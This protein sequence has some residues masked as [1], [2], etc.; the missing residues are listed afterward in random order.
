[1]KNV[2]IILI[3][4]FIGVVFFSSGMSILFAENQF[5]GLLDFSW[6]QGKIQTPDLTLFA[7]FVAFSQIITGFLLITQ[8]FATL[9]AL[10]LLPM[11]LCILMF[12][13]SLNLT[14]SYLTNYL[15]LALNLVLLMAD[16][17]RIKFLFSDQSDKLKNVSVDRSFPFHD[18]VFVIGMFI[19]I[20]SPVLSFMHPALAYFSIAVGLI[21]CFGIQ[22]YE[23]RLRKSLQKINKNFFK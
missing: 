8:R 4:V 16:Y 5:P 9:G 20:V 22:F 14:G 1:M 12:G 18:L 3:R 21:I 11:T 7:R 6:L 23:Y 15:L 10:M 17:H 2:L 19:V 13:F